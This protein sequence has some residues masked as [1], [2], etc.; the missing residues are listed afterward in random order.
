MARFI[1]LIFLTLLISSVTFAQQT[2]QGKV[3]G[4]GEP[5]FEASV[6]LKKSGVLITGALTDFDG[7][8]AI[9][10]FDPGTYDVEI[11]YVGFKTNIIQ[12]V[13]VGSSKTVVLDITLEENSEVIDVFVVTEYKIPLIEIDKT[14]GGGTLTSED[15][16]KLPTKNVGSIIATTVGTSQSKEGQAISIRGSRNNDQIVFVDGVRTRGASVPA[17]D[18]EQISVITSGLPAKYGDV[19]GGVTTITTKGPSLEYSGDAEVETSQYLDAYGYSQ[20]TVSVGGPIVTRKKTDVSGKEY[21]DA[22]IGFRI[23]GLYQTAKD[24]YPNY[25]GAYI[26]TDE[27]MDKVKADPLTLVGDGY[28]PSTTFM[29]DGDYNL[30]KYRPNARED[31]VNGSAK[32]D[33]KVS[34]GV[35]LTFGGNYNIN[36]SKNPIASWRLFNSERNPTEYS[37]DWR[38]FARFRHR[39]G[40]GDESANSFVK[41][42]IYSLQFD[43]SKITNKYQDIVHED[44]LWDY[45]YVSK[46]PTEFRSP[47]YARVDSLDIYGQPIWT[48]WYQRQV[49]GYVSEPDATG[50]TNP[51]MA[52]WLNYEGI[53]NNV[54]GNGFQGLSY[55]TSYTYGA[56]NILF[57]NYGEVYNLY[58]KTDQNQIAINLNGGFDIA[59]PKKK[60]PSK[61]SIE[62][63]L[64]YEQ[65]EDRSYSMNP[66]ALWLLGE[67]FINEGISVV[68]TVESGVDTFNLIYGTPGGLGTFAQNFR[69]KYGIASN[70]FVSLD[71]YSPNDLSL[72][73]FAADELLTS[74]YGAIG[75]NYYGY[76]YVGNVV[77]GDVK[78]N[79][80]FKAKDANGDLLRPVAPFQPIYTAG[81]IQD[82]FTFRDII[83][84]VGLRVDRYDA[85]TKVMK[86]IYSLYD[87]KT[88]GETSGFNHPSNVQSDWV[89]YGDDKDNPTRVVAYRS[90]DSWYDRNGNFVND[91]TVIF[92]TSQALPILT[93]PD[94][95]IQNVN[96]DPDPSFTD[97]IPQVNVMPRVAFSFPISNVAGF[98][99]HYD[100]LT[101]RPSSNGF[102]SALDY[103]YFRENANAGSIDN[104]NLKTSKVVDYEVGFQQKIS[105]TSA[106]ILTAYYKEMRDEIAI[107][108][109]NYA[110]PTPVYSTYGNLDFGTVKGFTAK[111]DMRRTNNLRL[112]L[113]YTL[114]FA[115]G[116]GSTS[117]S[118]RTI[119]FGQLKTIYPFTYDQRH[120]ISTIL[121]Y[122]YGSGKDYNG[123]VIGKARILENTGANL[124][125]T[126]NSGRPYT[127]YSEPLHFSGF[128]TQGSFNSSRLPWTTTVD[129]RFDRDIELG[130]K[131]SPMALNLYLRISNLFNTRNIVG[132]YPYSSSPDDD[133]YFSS[134][135]GS[136]E[137]GNQAFAE[138]FIR[139]YNLRLMNGNFFGLPRRIRLGAIF[140]F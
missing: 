137:L 57:T 101:R 87:T 45:G 71:N 140:N 20:A 39:I 129:L 94:D 46:F 139:Q 104:P 40:G 95:N 110:Y 62:F 61:H 116:T 2:V 23:S 38:A 69:D 41:N 92:G 48:K 78:F 138:D 11:S 75:L 44:R 117:E 96:F 53:D 15:V 80:F 70:S 55:R 103:Y 114:Q 8:Y 14:A 26:A 34:D 1:Y 68:D 106:I 127:K 130:K 33:F 100:V 81:Y 88:V 135:V 72:N 47:G 3:V 76:D 13:V 7:N 98:F 121:D 59:N 28:R 85:N 108:R 60:N 99:A 9:T 6:T 25:K 36:R 49:T 91:P 112:L 120:S 29:Q 133:G 5:L 12:G 79:D 54:V 24:P 115:D 37:D 4:G 128:G 126:V 82:K 93:N 18:I 51:A 63:G 19:T 90:G 58:Q 125:F 42:I 124:L 43:V 16:E 84:N 102:A 31:I 73:M 132:V 89:V 136:L 109:V 65:R 67:Q 83:F 122:R 50:S 113:N 32:L 30:I 134:V 56:G 111:F 74:G 64:I 77:R 86:D 118:N 27:F 52:Q 123:P 107:R 66:R 22:L 17:Q 97:Y 131:E 21:K 105:E 10:G 119:T 35:N